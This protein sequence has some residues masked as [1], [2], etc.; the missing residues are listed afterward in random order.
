MTIVYFVGFSLA[1]SLVVFVW[2][3]ILRHWGRHPALAP[4][5]HQWELRAEVVA[6]PIAGDVNIREVPETA[7]PDLLLA[8][9][10]RASGATRLVFTCK[11]C[12]A[13]E[14]KTVLGVPKEH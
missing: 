3:L 10:R 7:L 11:N 1:F 4:C 9:E 8:I 12:P 6:I 5:L 2:A 14:V 13:I